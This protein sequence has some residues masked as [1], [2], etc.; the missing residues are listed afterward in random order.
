MWALTNVAVT[1]C[2]LEAGPAYSETRTQQNLK[3]DDSVDKWFM[4]LVIFVVQ[5]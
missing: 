5:A 3:G 2:P 4:K 1:G